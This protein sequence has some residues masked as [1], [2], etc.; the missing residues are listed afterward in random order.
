LVSG[1][2]SELVS[3]TSF[4]RAPG[5][6]CEGGTTSGI[7][8]G[9]E[10]GAGESVKK[11]SLRLTKS[12]LDRLSAPDSEIWIWDTDTRGFFVRIYPSGVK[13]FAV[14]YRVGGRQTIFTIGK[15]GSPWTVE[16]A[17]GEAIKRLFDAAHGGDPQAEKLEKRHAL[18][19]S[20]LIDVYLRDGPQDKPNKR[21]RTWDND[22]LHLR[23]HIEP[24]I[25]PMKARAIS[26]ADVARMQTDIADGKT[27]RDSKTKKRGR[28]LVRGGNRAGAVAVV[29]LQAMYNWAIKRGMMA[30][31]PAK[32]VERFKSDPRERFL[33]K[34]EIERLFRTLTA[35]ERGEELSPLLAAAVRLLALTGARK[36]EITDL[37]WD[38]I[39][40]QRGLITL[41]ST[42]S[43]TGRKRIGLSAAAIELLRGLAND[44]EFVF[45]A[46]KGEGPTR[47]LQDAWEL[48]RLE[49]G[50]DGVRLHDLRHTFA[51]LAAAEGASL[52]FIGKALGHTQARTTE[53]YAHLTTTEVRAVGEAV[54]RVIGEATGDKR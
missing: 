27:A 32:G 7:G 23:R 5:G 1:V 8:Q 14:K 24:L 53:R 21:Q 9:I 38:E 54:A 52:Y 42:R 41:S 37:R 3:R 17:R 4:R 11:R 47:A 49:A 18:T 31:N 36:S 26:Q 39:D 48:I 51:S 19:V 40:F 12:V 30:T 25:G 28:S 50:L 10:K 20:E 34:E 13:T 2:V 33:A 16:T 29:T 35:L 45:P 15:Y 43:K 22:R 44:S 6:E 46:T